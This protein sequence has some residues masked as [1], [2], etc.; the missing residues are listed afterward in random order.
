M[1]TEEQKGRESVESL[2]VSM[3]VVPE[4]IADSQKDNFSL[5]S[6]LDLTNNLSD[7]LSDVEIISDFCPPVFEPETW[8]L[9][10][11]SAMESIQL[12]NRG[13]S[14]S[15]SAP[16]IFVEEH[17]VQVKIS[18][19]SESNLI[20]SAAAEIKILPPVKLS[21]EVSSVYSVVFQQNQFPLISVLEL[22]NHSSDSFGLTKVLAEFD[23]PDFDSTEWVIDELAAGQSIC[24]KE[25]QLKFSASALEALTER[26]LIQLKLSVYTDGVL[27]CSKT[28]D[29]QI[30]PKNQWGGEFHMPELLSAFVTPDTHYCDALIKKASNLLA[31]EGHDSKLDGYQSK[32]RERPYLIAA[33]LWSVVCNEGISYCVPPASFASTGQKIRLSDDIAKSLLATCLDTALLFSSCLE[34]AGLN[35]V[36][37]LTKGHA[38]VGVWLIDE[39]FSL[40][41]NNDP[42]DLR[43]RIALKDL[44]LFETTLATNDSPIKF[45]QAI[46]EANRK[47]S[48]QAEDDF[49]YVLDVKQARSRK[50]SPI[51]FGVR[52]PLPGQVKGTEK[53]VVELSPLP[54]LP[55]VKPDE[56]SDEE[57]T[58]LGRVE[59]WRRKLLDLS[60]RNKLLNIRQRSMGFQIIC[61]DLDLLEDALASGKKYN[62]V[63]PSAG[64]L[65]NSERDSDRYVLQTGDDLEVEFVHDQLNRGNLIASCSER[66]LEKNL[67]NLFRKANSDMQE[68]GA[69]TL[70]LAFGML[71][72]KEDSRSEQ[73]YKAPLIL[74][75]VKLTRTSARAKPKLMQLPDEEPVFNLT[76]IELLQQDF[77]IDLSAFQSELPKDESGVDVKGIWNTVRTKIKDTPGFEV[78]EDLVLSNFSFSKYLMWKDLSDRIDD[79]KTSPFVDHL[80]E[81]PTQPY[82]FSADFIE[83]SKVDEKIDPTTF[84]APLNADSSQIVAIDASAKG[85]DFIL[86]GPP[87]TGKSET[88]ANIISHNI[89]IGRKV[90]FVSEKMAALDV[91]YR[92]LK[93]V[94]LGHLCMELH[95]NKASK[96][97]VIDQLNEAWQIREGATQVEW[98]E[99]ASALGL[100]R[101]ELNVYVEELHKKS[102]FGYSA[103]DAIARSVHYKSTTLLDFGWPRDIN[104]APIKNADDV[105]NLLKIAG[106][107]G[108]AYKGVEHIDWE[109]FPLVKES[110]WS[111]L[112]QAN[113]VNAA[114][115]L[116]EGLTGFRGEFAK[117]LEALVSEEVREVNLE[118]ISCW[119]DVANIC[120]KCVE[121]SNCFAFSENSKELIEGLD[122]LSELKG[123]YDGLV[124]LVN[125]KV[126]PDVIVE[127]PVKEWVRE[128]AKLGASEDIVSKFD[129]ERTTIIA[130]LESLQLPVQVDKGSGCLQEILSLET[131]CGVLKTL[132]YCSLSSEDIVRLPVKK[133]VEHQKAGCDSLSEQFSV[134]KGVLKE[135]QGH[136]VQIAEDLI[137]FKLDS[138]ESLQI[139][140]NELITLCGCSLSPE[141]I[142][143][144][145]VS[146]WIEKRDEVSEKSAIARFVAKQKINKQMRLSGLQKAKDLSVLDLYSNLIKVT[147]RIHSDAIREILSLCQDLID[148]TALMQSLRIDLALKFYESLFD[149]TVELKE[150]SENYKGDG[151][152]DSW[153][154]TPGQILKRKEEGAL[155]RRALY[156]AAGQ[157]ENPKALIISAREK[158]VDNR[159]F[160]ESSILLKNAET[161]IVQYA[162]IVE[163]F[164]DF[165]NLA[166]QSELGD[167]SFECV[168]KSLGGI[169]SSANSLNAWCHWVEAKNKAS[170]VGLDALSNALERSLISWERVEEQTTSALSIWLAPLLIDQSDV[171]RKFS[172]SQQDSLVEKFRK[173]DCDVAELT[174]QFVAAKLASGMPDTTGSNAPPQVG[175]LT[176]EIVANRHKPVRQLVQELGGYLLELTPCFMM[177]P[178]SVAQFLP[179][180]YKAFDLVVFDE[181]SQI[182]VWDAVGA[183][184]RGKN[185]IVVGDPKQ[186]PP[187]NFFKRSQ[188]V[189]DSDEADLES[190]L[191]QAMAARVSLHRLTGHYRSRHESLIAFSN[192]Q[193]YQNSLLTYPSAD[194]RDSVVT[195]H[196]V[197]GV[198]TQKIKTNPIEAKAVVAEVVR[199]LNDSELQKL[200]I[201]IVTLNTEQQ[202]LIED[203]LDDERRKDTSL[204]CFFSEESREPIF[205][206]NLE[207]VQGDQ[208]DVICL[209]IGYGP[210]EPE[211]QTMSMN[212]GPL[213]RQGGERRLNVA[214]TRASTEMLVFSSFDSAMIDLSRTSSEAIKHL[215][216]YIDYAARGPVAIAQIARFSGGVDQFDSDFEQ[217][218]ALRLREKGW[219]VRTQIGV[220]KF[221]I[222]LGILN[223]DAG[224]AFLAGVECD[225]ATYHSSPSARDRDRVRQIILENLGW[226]LVR[227]WSTDYFINPEGVISDIHQQLK[228]I[229]ENDRAER[230]HVERERV[231]QEQMTRE[232]EVEESWQDDVEE[233]QPPAEMD[234][235]LLQDAP[236]LEAEAKLGNTALILQADSVKELFE[237][238]PSLGVDDD[239]VQK[240][241]AEK[242]GNL[243]AKKFFETRQLMMLDKVAKHIMELKRTVTLAELAHDVSRAYG[244]R[245]TSKKQIEHV[246]RA[247][248]YWAVFKTHGENLPATVWV[249]NSEVEE[250]ISFRGLKAWGVKRS[251]TTIQVEERR[252]LVLQSMKDF[253]HDPVDGL[254]AIFELKKRHEKTAQ[255]FQSWIDEVEA[256]GLGRH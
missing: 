253:P 157:L 56:I 137:S 10:K 132:I 172:A 107:L 156:T 109:V 29:L 11:L 101:K 75:P 73:S 123:R 97:G 127:L 168:Q 136:G 83:Q 251:W 149:A 186:M 13:F 208:R 140:F 98:K 213:N 143:A 4:H 63:A 181:A 50:I 242:F 145:P 244:L 12:E 165:S 57:L 170:S 74:L 79:L 103:R 255:E 218:V 248:K 91:V 120:I 65:A 194:T 26:R 196:R 40:L 226:K 134:E 163:C 197:N 152:L 51:N 84:Y 171:L 173:L 249:D 195:L 77:E 142:V 158:L 78:V 229:L 135:L 154:E 31:K 237:E 254:F 116:G 252:G 111:N 160:L 104:T 238:K 19:F 146:D 22:T 69:N 232:F 130:S 221:R 7:D 182:T 131:E 8:T 82:S 126:A 188:E 148:K 167:T 201:G 207:T 190:I 86:E 45:S 16:D 90:L 81:K 105:E 93:N 64:P 198:Y 106:T 44:L 162:E 108:L 185:S 32:T 66:E 112:W 144:L 211:A 180:D 128:R 216:A 18:V 174:G 247:I 28:A 23:P 59:Q 246:S 43:N 70:F 41:T 110:D 21:L 9:D 14:W 187:T 24:L 67:I 192:S 227:I 1:T 200:S 183:I 206:K 256:K 20:T 161:F 231:E 222:D 2:T 125:L 230:A 25:R 241:I 117:F 95:S 191:D 153:Q 76:L 68:G 6:L 214:I 30:L 169:I 223:P 150:L 236:A 225:G 204:E 27:V 62:I 87:G 115:T 133:W 234:D 60:K 17:L 199:R 113:L 121:Q 209:S 228:K 159:E 85:K 184:A 139:Q 217:D 179:S 80:I 102:V 119:V 46:G 71:R 36:I 124:S 96:K 54:T 35:S 118:L 177:S 3:N 61:P 147:A 212:F 215:K 235:L 250:V 72:W 239:Q 38:M 42:V 47:I 245:K 114:K 33:A 166:G 5:I 39:S 210:T 205:V 219:E 94:G 99:K 193:Y 88:I 233:E 164:N 189:D 138:L 203:L 89:A 55:P 243:E 92:R 37:A 122:Y 141:E 178:L 48:E 53:V 52:Q 155:I 49:V 202:R 176:R 129:F 224:G 100:L 58:S 151:I 175:V 240:S 34:Q 220:S 15:D